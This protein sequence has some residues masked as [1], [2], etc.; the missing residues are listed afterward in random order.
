MAELKEYMKLIRRYIVILNRKCNATNKISN[1]EP[2]ESIAE[3]LKL[4]II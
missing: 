2:V 4:V 1:M 3:L